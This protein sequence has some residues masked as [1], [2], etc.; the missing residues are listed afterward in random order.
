MYLNFQ[1]ELSAFAT[2]SRNGESIHHWVSYTIALIVSQHAEAICIV[3]QVDKRKEKAQSIKIN[4][5]IR[6]WTFIRI[7][8]T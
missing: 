1:L 3:S 7:F 2:V 8:I 6:W 4:D 5:A